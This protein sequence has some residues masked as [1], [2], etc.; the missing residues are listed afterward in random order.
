MSTRK[1]CGVPAALVVVLGFTAASGVVLSQTEVVAEL[2]GVR[3]TTAD[4][5]RRLL[6]MRGRDYAT[7]LKVV[8]PE[9]RAE[10]LGGMVEAHV[11]ARAARDEG[12]AAQPD[13]AFDVEQAAAEALAARYR[14]AL[15]ARLAPSEAE[16]RDWYAAHAG[17]LR[18]VSRVKARQVLLATETEAGAALAEIRAGRTFEEVAAARSID[19]PTRAAGGDLG[20][21][22]RGVMVPEFE[23]ALFALAAGEVGGPVKTAFG[24]HVIRVDEIDGGTIPAFDAVAGR[25]HDLIVDERLDRRRAAL[26]AKYAAR[27]HTDVLDRYGRPTNR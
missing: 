11:L 13:V 9:G 16:A 5:S 12:F 2:S 4:L 1:G 25:V 23:Q 21:V 18:T 26:E 24:Y 8:T 27:V 7:T 17:R 6:A 15:R 19:V 22:P 14:E 3:I 10:I 20:W